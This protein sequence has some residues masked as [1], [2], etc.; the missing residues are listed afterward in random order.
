[1]HGKQSEEDAELSDTL[2]FTYVCVPTPYADLNEKL[3]PVRS[4]DSRKGKST[5][6][7]GSTNSISTSD[8][9]IRHSLRDG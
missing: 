4:R 3:N 9:D 1:M 7:Y 6:N 2:D 8:D 5:K